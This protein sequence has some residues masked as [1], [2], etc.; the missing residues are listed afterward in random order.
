MHADLC[1]QQRSSSFICDPLPQ[2]FGLGRQLPDPTGEKSIPH[3]TRGKWLLSCERQN[4]F[5]LKQDYSEKQ[6]V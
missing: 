1:R 5:W 3:K 6:S 2:I 4:P